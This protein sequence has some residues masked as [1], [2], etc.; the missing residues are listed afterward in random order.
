MRGTQAEYDIEMLPA[1]NPADF[2]YDLDKLCTHLLS[3]ERLTP[4]QEGIEQHLRWLLSRSGD[5][6]SIATAL[7]V[8]FSQS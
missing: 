2:T 7:E 8:A 6:M 5:E 4:F 3:G 1:D